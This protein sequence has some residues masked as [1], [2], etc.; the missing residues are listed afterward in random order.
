MK[1]ITILAIVGIVLI[2]LAVI[3]RRDNATGA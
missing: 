3:L 1:T 2:A